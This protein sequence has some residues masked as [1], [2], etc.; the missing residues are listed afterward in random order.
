MGGRTILHVDMDAFFAAVEQLRRPELRGRP[1]VVGGDGDPRKRG[2]VSTASYEARAFGVH[3]AMPLRVAYRRCPHAV[4]LPVDF[5]AYRAASERMHAILRETGARVES[6]GL[7]EAFLDCTGLPDDGETI[8]RAIKARIADELHLTASVGVGPNKLVAKIASGLVKPDGLTVIREDEVAARLAPLPV[9]VLWGV[10]PKTAARLR[11]VLGVRTVGDL[12]AMPEARLRA[13]FGPRHG[14]HLHETALGRDESP[15]ETDW[16]PKSI[17]RER[18]FQVDLRRPQEIRE[19][20][21]RLAREVAGDLR[22][23]GYRTANV[24]LK[25]RLVPFRT[26]T[27]SRTL[28]APTDDPAEIALAAAR[29]LDRVPLDRPVRLLGVR[30]AK[31]SPASDAAPTPCAGAGPEPDPAPPA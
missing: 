14:A 10:G 12:A 18:T 24:T 4:F 1:V 6:L 7:D 29:L 28:T 5:A 20:V 22:E 13:L 9:T 23:Q 17:S 25:V 3:S 27:R 15:V 30:V 21:G 26:L 11:E 16:A 19:T 8:A 31:L 2:V